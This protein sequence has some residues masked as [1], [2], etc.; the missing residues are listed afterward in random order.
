MIDFSKPSGYSEALYSELNVSVDFNGHHFPGVLDEGDDP[1]FKVQWSDFK[2][3]RSWIVGPAFPCTVCDRYAS[4]KDFDFN[5][6]NT[7]KYFDRS[8][9]NFVTGLEC[10]LPHSKIVEVDIPIP[11]GK[12]IVTDDLVHSFEQVT[13]PYAAS[14]NSQRGRIEETYRW[15]EY[16]VL[17]VST[18][19]AASLFQKND[20]SLC[21]TSI[22]PYDTHE[23]NDY[24]LEKVLSTPV[25]DLWAYCVTD[26]DNF[27][28]NAKES[29]NELVK[30]K[31]GCVDVVDVEPGVYRFRNYVETVRQHDFPPVVLSDIQKI[32]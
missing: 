8:T 4:V 23:W 9:N 26:Y 29:F 24:G 13:D 15:S 6:Q 16:G 5:K 17:Y 10:D 27:A 30:R 18:I 32:S 22:D 20:G 7:L 28:T 21:F 19:F 14:I 25:H 2:G 1:L 3:R 12:M 11:S 31:N